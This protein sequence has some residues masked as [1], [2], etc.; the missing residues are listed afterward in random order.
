MSIGEAFDGPLDFSENITYRKPRIVGYPLD[1][2]NLETRCPLNNKRHYTN[3]TQLQH[4]VGKLDVLP[5]EIIPHILI[6]PDLPTLTTFRRVNHRAMSLVDS[7]HQYG[8]VFKHWPNV[9]R[10]IINIRA[11]YFDCKTLYQTLSSSKCKT[12]DRFGGYLYLVTCKHLGIWLPSHVGCSRRELKHPP[13]IV[14]LPGRIMLFDRQVTAQRESLGNSC[15]ISAPNLG[16]SGQSVDWGV[17]CA[18]CEDNT[19]PTTHL[20]K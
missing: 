18:G 10:S 16:A 4:S 1:D 12:R 8:M 17:H 13:Y 3:N 15:I 11:D 7:L 19:Q 14:S 9:L 6:V 5:L 20:R 2:A